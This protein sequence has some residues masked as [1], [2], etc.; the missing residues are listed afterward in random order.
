MLVEL[1][2]VFVVQLLPT[3]TVVPEAPEAVIVATAEADVYGPAQAGV[4]A[5]VGV[6]VSDAAAVDGGSEEIANEG[7]FEVEAL[8]HAVEEHGVEVSLDVEFAT[9]HEIGMVIRFD[10]AVPQTLHAS[11]PRSPLVF[12]LHVSDERPCSMPPVLCTTGSRV[13]YL[14]ESQTARTW[15]RGLVVILNDGSQNRSSSVRRR[16]GTCH[17]ISTRV[18]LEGE[19]INKLSRTRVDEPV[20]IIPGGVGCSALE[21]VS[22]KRVGGAMEAS[23]AAGGRRSM[24][25]VLLEK[26]KSFPTREREYRVCGLEIDDISLPTAPGPPKVS[27]FSSS[28]PS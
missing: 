21:S 14:L 4:A 28:P 20:N 10:Y 3:V 6:G 17:P 25:S 8:E 5:A 26:S 15:W 13:H 2:F 16:M 22:L 7:A 23:S 1:Q 12:A 11:Q 18:N 24:G 9:K 19:L 27:S